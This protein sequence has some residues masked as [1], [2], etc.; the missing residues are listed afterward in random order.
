M[1]NSILW[2][3]IPHTNEIKR[4]QLVP[5]KVKPQDTTQT[6]SKALQKIQE[7]KPEILEYSDLQPKR[8]TTELFYKAPTLNIS[9]KQQLLDLENFKSTLSKVHKISTSQLQ[10]KML[11]AYDKSEKPFYTF[12]EPLK[13]HHDDKTSNNIDILKRVQKMNKEITT[14]NNLLI[15]KAQTVA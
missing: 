13:I 14:Q 12:S 10:D 6:F 2:Q 4:A 15:Y 1:I 5:S 11:A 3:T 9:L 7:P 8:G